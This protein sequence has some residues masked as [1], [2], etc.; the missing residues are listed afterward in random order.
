MKKLAFLFLFL[1]IVGLG[2]ATPIEN[3]AFFNNLGYH[4]AA[5]GHEEAAKAAFEQ[6]LALDSSYIKARENLAVLSFQEEWYELAVTHLTYL[7]TVEDR[8]AWHFDLAQNLVAHA[9]FVE[10]NGMQA[11]ATLQEALTHFDAAGDFPHAAENAAVVRRV[12]G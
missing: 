5:E 2:T 1:L 9:R 12:L 8:A 4:L 11:V 6:A 10:T 3:P 7:L